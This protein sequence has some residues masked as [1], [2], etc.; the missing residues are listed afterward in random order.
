MD[1][2]KTIVILLSSFLQLVSCQDLKEKKMKEQLYEWTPAASNPTDSSDRA[3]FIFMVQSS[4]KTAEGYPGGL[5]FATSL[6]GWGKF[7]TGPGRM[8]GTPIE[9]EAIY[10]AIAEDKF[11]HLKTPLLPEAEMKDYM[12][13]WYQRDE[14]DKYEQQYI[15]NLNDNDD[16]DYLRFTNLIFGFGPQGMVVLWAG[17][18]PL[19]IELARYQAQEITGS[20]AEYEQQMRRIWARPRSGLREKYLIPDLTS[21]KWEK[22]RRR[23]TI[24]LNYVS[25]NSGFRI[26]K[27]YYECYNG[28][29]EFLLRPYIL[30]E[31]GKSRALPNFI[32]MDW[33][34]GLGQKYKGRIFFKEKILFEKFEKFSKDQPIDFTIR[35]NKENTKLEIQ[36]NN[37]PLEIQNFRIYKNDENYKES[38]E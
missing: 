3:M 2:L 4:I 17:Y 27:T 10:Y 12:S 5:P 30:N 35:F 24:K 18:G 33:E 22:Y 6:D 25:E 15:R 1:N 11:Y 9:A 32:E 26:F 23:Y 31:K 19:R 20:T 13:R 34:T 21:E 29:A 7:A 37:E 38:Y 36:I 14:S 16:L 8:K 28:E